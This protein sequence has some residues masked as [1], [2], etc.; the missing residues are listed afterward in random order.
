MKKTMLR[1]PSV[2]KTLRSGTSSD[3]SMGE[4]MVGLVTEVVRAT[5]EVRFPPLTNYPRFAAS[6]GPQFRLPLMV[7][8][9]E[10]HRQNR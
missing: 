7:V 4:S 5:L 6:V 9:M 1:V 2:L 10:K 8:T 3:V